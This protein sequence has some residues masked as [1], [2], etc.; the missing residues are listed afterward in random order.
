M[1][2][3][4]FLSDLGYLGLFAWIFAE[5]LGL[6]IPALPVLVAAGSFVSLGRLSFA[7]CVVLILVA[8]L[9]ADLLW[10]YVG[11]AKGPSILHFICR[12]SWKP[13]T[14]ISKTKGVFMKFG[15]QTLLFAKFVPGLNTLAP[16]LAGAAEVSLGRF[17]AYDVAGAA[18]WGLVPLLVG[19]GLREVVPSSD[20]AVV[21]AR[22]HWL[23]LVGAGLAL[24]LGWRFVRRRIYLRRL[25]AEL[26]RGVTV[27]ELREMIE[28]EEPV[29]LLDIRHPINF[30]LNPVLL[31]GALRIGYN[32]IESRLA[33]IPLE[34][35][36][37]AYCDC[38]NDQASV[39]AVRHLHRLGAKSA[40]VLK[41]G[42]REWE[43]RGFATETRA[44]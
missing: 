13:N 42:L 18:I 44:A 1:A 30:R 15:A 6:P 24:F 39:L 35:P 38:P 32:E 41:G 2:H 36:L 20:A 25:H 3:L 23:E 9:A 10:F 26:M 21:F 28:R 14:C 19:M 7:P 34:T 27:D 12:I 4:P 11:R 22:A 17:L 5:Q 40:R 31:P 8:S 29:T 43:A 16:P 37:V 33:E